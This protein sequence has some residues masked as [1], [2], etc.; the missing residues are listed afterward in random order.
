DLRRVTLHHE[1]APLVGRV[2][3]G[4]LDDAGVEFSAAGGLTM[5][6]DPVGTAVMHAAGERGNDAFVVRKAQK[7]HGMARQ[8]EG[9][10]VAGRKVVLLEDPTTTGGPALTAVDGV[11][12]AGGEVQSVSDIVDRDTGAAEHEAETAGVSYLYA[13]SK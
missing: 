2:M 8:V 4:L 1:A 10:D 11:R 3:L 12:A 7:R 9:L 5:G 13:I 6:A